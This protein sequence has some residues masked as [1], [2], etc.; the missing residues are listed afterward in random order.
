MAALRNLTPRGRIG[1]GAGLAGVLLV[2]IVLF[3]IASQA[4]YTTIMAGIDPAQTS[5]ITSALDQRGIRYELQSGGTA[6]AVDAAHVDDARVALSSQGIGAGG[7]SPG[8]ELFDKQKLGASDFQQQVE[9]Q[10]ALEG[11]VSRTIE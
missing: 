3:K 7:S 2:A 10:R 11:E 4:S 9:Y 1:L 5:K 8:F 6:L